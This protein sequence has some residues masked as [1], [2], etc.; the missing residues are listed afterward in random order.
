MAFNNIP[1]NGFP[2]LPDIED[3]EAVVKDVNALKSS[4]L[5]LTEDVTDLNEQKANQITIAPFFNSETSYDVGDLVYY[6]GLTYRCTNAHEGEWDADDFA[7]TTIANELDTLKSGLI[8]KHGVY[9]Y[10]YLVTLAEFDG[11]SSYGAYLNTAYTA[12]QTYISNLPNGVLIHIDRMNID[13]IAI[14]NPSS[15]IG[16]NSNTVGGL[17]FAQFIAFDIA[18]GHVVVRKVDAIGKSYEM[19]D[20]G[21]YSD[22]TS[23]VPAAGGTISV[24]VTTYY[25]MS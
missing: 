1:P 16:D 25:P 5:G 10:N 6:N 17:L 11:I 3:L 21:V 2:A 9:E 7:G 23:N 8:G 14:N 13:N 15:R 12:L 4:V 20:D 22:L 24:N 18:N 19:V